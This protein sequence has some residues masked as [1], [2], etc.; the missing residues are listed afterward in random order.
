MGRVS[1]V[2]GEL[3]G[4]LG[5]TVGYKSGL[6]LD[7]NQIADATPP[8]HK[9]LVEGSGEDGLH[10]RAEDYQELVAVI[11][12]RVGNTPTPT[13]VRPGIEMF[14]KYRDDPEKHEIALQVQLWWIDDIRQKSAKLD[15]SPYNPAPVIQRARERFG[16]AGFR[17]ANEFFGLL[18]LSLHQSPWG[19]FRRI[20]W[21]DLADL[22]DLFDSEELE[23]SHGAFLDQRYVDY[24]HKNFD[25]IDEMNWR[26]FEAL[27]AEY[28]V[29]AGC[30]VEIGPGRRDGG[31]DVRVWLSG[32]RS[33]SA[34]LLLVQCK[35]RKENVPQV[36]VK[37][38]YADVR[39][40]GAA[41]G[42]V[43][44]TRKLAPS[45]EETRTARQYPIHAAERETLRQW[46]GIMRTPDTGVFCGY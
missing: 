46:L 30:E 17:V 42:L 31:V 39:D 23:P 45:A 7:R 28:F 32:D 37:A 40:E 18:V 2:R 11:L 12:H 10:F 3:L 33:D 19:F 13:V 1:M 44:T 22:A 34:A 9:M 29:N 16:L 20:E 14:A 21:D 25:K 15:I 26:K 27:T 5:E 41:G 38:L 35:R 43:V 36:V 8:E 6:A 4:S 24:L